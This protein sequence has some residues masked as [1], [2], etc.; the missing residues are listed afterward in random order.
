MT[1]MHRALG[2]PPIEPLTPPYM[3]DQLRDVEIDIGPRLGP[4]QHPPD[5]RGQVAGPH[6]PAP[7]D[8]PVA[9]DVLAEAPVLALQAPE[10]AQRLQPVDAPVR[11]GTVAL[12]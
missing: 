3:R 1:F 7:G 6:V 10:P 5:R 8:V 12:G 4:A 2:N 11:R 9:V